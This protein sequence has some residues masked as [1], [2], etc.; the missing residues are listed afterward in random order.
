MGVE[1]EPLERNVVIA[2]AKESKNFAVVAKALQLS[3]PAEAEE[4]YLRAVA[5]LQPVQV[6]E[7]EWVTVYGIACAIQKSCVWTKKMLIQL[8]FPS[9]V[10]RNQAGQTSPH[11]PAAAVEALRDLAREYPESGAWLT[12]NAIREKLEVEYDWVERQLRK[13]GI[14]G[15]IRVRKGYGKP[16]MH[17]PPLAVARLRDL[18]AVYPAAGDWLT[19]YAIKGRVERSENWVRNRLSGSDY[20]C[21]V[22]LDD[23]GVPRDHYPPWVLDDLRVRQHEDNRGRGRS[24]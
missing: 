15:E 10:R 23:H 8:Q 17:F 1:L 16:M 22:R 4:I 11:Y 14:E 24:K 5:K 12:I 13:L 21:Q 9:Q 6:K 7:P 20:P 3:S 18:K 2:A 19:A